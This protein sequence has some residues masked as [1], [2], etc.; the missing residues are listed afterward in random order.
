[1]TDSMQKSVT[2]FIIAGLVGCS[3]PQHKTVPTIATVA[4]SNSLGGEARFV[5]ELGFR[6]GCLVAIAGA[7]VATPIFDRDVVLRADGSAINDIRHGLQI[8]VGKRFAAGGAWLRDNGSGWSIA[9]IEGASG[10]HMPPGCP[11][12]TVVRLHDFRLED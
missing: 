1:M 3:T 6:N 2:V 9:D 5:G 11:V 8:P 12:E 7:K 4:T 10:A